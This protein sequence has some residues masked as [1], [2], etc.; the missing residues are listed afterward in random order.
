M[1]NG[2]RWKQWGRRGG[3]PS[4]PHD[5]Q[6]QGGTARIATPTSAVWCRRPRFS[7]GHRGSLESAISLK[8]T[9]EVRGER[10]GASQ[11]LYAARQ[12]GYG[13]VGA[14]PGA[15]RLPSARGSREEEETAMQAII[16]VE[17]SWGMNALQLGTIL[18]YQKT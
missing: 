6:M 7:A 1:L 3:T 11:R 4:Y 8:H 14:R 5:V 13:C 12:G 15:S 18:R 10:K 9:E 16:E 2:M 17:N